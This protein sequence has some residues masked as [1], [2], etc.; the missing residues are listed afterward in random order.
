MKRIKTEVDLLH[1]TDET[2]T[3]EVTYDGA[4]S[5][6]RSVRPSMKRFVSGMIRHGETFQGPY[7]QSDTQISPG[8]VGAGTEFHMVA[9]YRKVHKS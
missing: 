3:V 7:I 6:R 1:R 2:I 8:P 9:E 4:S 5:W